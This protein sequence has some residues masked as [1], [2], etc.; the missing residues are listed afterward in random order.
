MT[1]AHDTSSGRTASANSSS[2]PSNPACTAYS[3][4]DMPRGPGSVDASPFGPRRSWTGTP[5]TTIVDPCHVIA[6]FSPRGRVRFRYWVGDS[7]LIDASAGAPAADVSTV[8]ISS[9]LEGPG[10]PG[11]IVTGSVHDPS[12]IPNST[13]PSW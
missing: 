9:W 10:G 2:V 4:A 6:G 3:Y 13:S 5:S 7:P 12:S 8:P 1:C 11:G